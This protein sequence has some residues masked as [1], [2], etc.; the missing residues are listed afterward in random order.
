MGKGYSRVWGCDIYLRTNIQ[1]DMTTFL[2]NS[3]NL[4]L[5]YLFMLTPIVIPEKSSIFVSFK[6]PIKRF[7]LGF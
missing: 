4:I 7:G 2:K 3:Q 6:M 5:Y 1:G